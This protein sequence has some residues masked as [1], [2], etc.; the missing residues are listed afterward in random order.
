VEEPARQDLCQRG[1]GIEV[2][3][4]TGGLARE[5]YMRSMVEVIAPLPSEPVPVEFPRI[6]QAG[7]VKVR[8]GDHGGWPAR[9]S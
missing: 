6:E 3:V 4:V 7:T 8:L 9:F 5:V 2:A 1:Q